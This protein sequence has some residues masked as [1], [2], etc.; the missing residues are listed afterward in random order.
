[1]AAAK[2]YFVSKT[3]IVAEIK[4]CGRDPS[5]FITTYAQ[6]SHPTKGII[7]FAMYKYQEKLVEK[8]RD[9]RY[10]I[11]LKARQLGITTVVA[12]Y[13]AWLMVFHRNKEVL[14]LATKL[15][16]A[17]NLLR[18]TKY[19]IKHLPTWLRISK[20][21]VDNQE[22]FEL[23]NG[24]K[25]QASAT[26]GD[27]GRSDALS[28]LILD[29]AAHIDKIEDIWTAIGPTI[30][31]GGSCVAL[32]TPNG[33]GGW[34]H[35]MYTGAETE[36]NEFQ[37]T[38]LMWWE[39]PEQD[40]AWFDKETKNMSPREIQQEYCCN[41]N[42]SGET[43]FDPNDLERIEQGLKE[44]VWKTGFDRNFWIWE[45]YNPKNSYLI[46]ADVAR[47]D[48]Q[49]YSTFHI[50][51]LEQM[52]IVAEYQGKLTTDIFANLLIE[53]GREFGNCMI[54]VENNNIGFNVLDKLR[55]QEYPN[56]Y[57]SMKSTHEYVEQYIAEQSSSSVPGFTMSMKTRPL[58]IAK[59]EEYIRNNLIKIYSKRMLAEMRTFIWQNG[60]ASAMS[61]Y[62]DDLT[63]AAA[64]LCWVKETALQANERDLAYRKAFLNNIMVSKRRLDSSVS[65]LNNSAVAN[66]ER[67]KIDIARYAWFYAK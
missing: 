14:V 51:S 28:L 61:G 3:Q 53:A 47:G 44:P 30:T 46:A 9:H 57:F 1:M 38:K 15:K 31:R 63:T 25:A 20:I 32:S 26:S 19:I 48:G 41:F 65:T 67:A 59:L 42:M 39:H 13:V 8:F 22:S 40:Q 60:R 43:V 33:T 11:I 2:K 34:F 24:S 58:I 66:K 49:D 6:I 52:A 64:I 18:K 37:P 12:G 56:I 55:E 23:S 27:A 5:Y 21:D 45:K 50:L 16:A 54:V 62:N 10:N 36:E 29:E 35:K 4:K 7:P 17:K